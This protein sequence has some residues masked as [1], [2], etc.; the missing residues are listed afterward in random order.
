MSP[1]EK[2]RYDELANQL[3]ELSSSSES[4]ETFLAR[5]KFLVNEMWSIL[6]KKKSD[7]KPN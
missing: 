1:E 5:H 4:P 7:K 2:K 6:N 3:E